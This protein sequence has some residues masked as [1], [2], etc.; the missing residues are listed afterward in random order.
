MRNNYLSQSVS[1]PSFLASVPLFNCAITLLQDYIK[2]LG[3]QPQ[4][5][6]ELEGCYQVNNAKS[7]TQKLNFDLINQYLRSVDIDGEIVSE[8]WRN[9]WEY[10]SLFNGQ[11]PLKEAMNLH[12]ML[13]QLPQ[14]FQRLYGQHG[15]INT[16][17][18]P[19]VWSGDQGKLA[20]G[21]SQIFTDDTRAVH[22]PNAIQLNASV[23]NKQGMNLIAEKN[24]GEYLQFCFLRTSFEC[25]LLYL[26][27]EAAFERLLLKSYYGLAQELCSP[28]DIS[29]G[30]QGSIA[31]YQKLGKHNQNMGEEPLL[32]DR[33]NKVIS[34]QQNWQ[35]TARI[36]HRLGASSLYYNPY[37]NVIYG[38]LNIV[39]A[40]EAYENDKCLSVPRFVSSTLP[41]SLFTHNDDIVSLGAIDIFTASSWFSES[42][43][44]VQEKYSKTN[45]TLVLESPMLLG[46]KI[47]QIILNTYQVNITK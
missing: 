9:Q 6:F 34:V 43:N 23:L 17:I 46:N 35:K 20:T 12:Q 28:I 8:Y 39:D 21:S 30:H 13:T 11:S 14:I 19:V 42:L 2:E 22:I 33:Y 41:K 4:I 45:S 10:V 38:L 24:F 16:L 47:K 26:P 25:S 3:Y 44:T 37:V 31:L 15:V 7:L 27:E 36:E 1:S 18:E 32:F 40:I 5:H 29:G